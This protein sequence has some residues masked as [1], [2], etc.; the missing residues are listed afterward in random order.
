MGISQTIEISISYPI[1]F[2]EKITTFQSRTVVLPQSDIDTD[3]ILPPRF[4]TTTTR[5]GMGDALF[6]D[7]RYDHDGDLIEDFPLNQ[8][9][10]R[11]CRVL[12]AGNNFGCGSSRG[13][14]PVQKFPCQ[15]S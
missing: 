7:W 10:A 5:A 6:A 9:A 8:P 12:V 4:L 2:M 14:L 15:T 1:Y 13:R 3:Q 11:G